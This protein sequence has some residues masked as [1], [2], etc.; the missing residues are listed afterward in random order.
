MQPVSRFAISCA[1]LLSIMTSLSVLTDRSV[2]AA[3]AAAALQQIHLSLGA[4]A[5]QV[6]VTWVTHSIDED[7]A[8][9]SVNYWL[10]RDR[11][12]SKTA[13]GKTSCF[14]P[15]E[16]RELFVH[17]ATLTDLLPRQQYGSPFFSDCVIPESQ[18]DD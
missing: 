8:A 3:P 16:A 9:A 18:R 4:T 12:S 14:R 5:D 6:V 10:T 13:S 1:F 7:F 17:R 15:S 2:A 11:N